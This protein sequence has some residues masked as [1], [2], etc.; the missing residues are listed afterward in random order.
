[1]IGCLRW[2]IKLGRADIATEVSLLSRHLDL[3]CRG[4]LDQCFNIYA[5]IKQQHYSK[6]LMNPDYMN[7]E[8]HYPN[9]FNYKAEWFEFYGDDKEDIPKNLPRALV[10]GVEVTAWVHADHAGYKLTRRSHTRLLIFV[11]SAPIVWYSKRQAT[12]ESYTFG[13]GVV[14]IR[15]CLELVKDL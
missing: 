4:H 5:Y 7:V 11:Y 6:L 15:K 8:D 14:A 10:K 12:I 2:A 3:P 1:M 13:P 9:S